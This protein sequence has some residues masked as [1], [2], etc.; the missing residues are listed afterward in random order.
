MAPEIITR[1]GYNF[2]ADFYTLGTL[3]YE[4]VVG[5]PPYLADRQR[6]LFDKIINQEPYYPPHISPNLKLFLSQLLEKNL[7]ER[8]GS[9]HGLS[10]IVNHPW[11]RDLDIV[12]I[13]QK[14]IK[15]P[16]IPDIYRINFAREFI[17]ARATFVDN[18]TSP[19]MNHNAP[20]HFPSAQP[21]TIGE[22][23]NPGM[24]RKFA[25]F[26]FYSN[27]DDPY[28]KF[29]DSIFVS[30]ENTPV[31]SPREERGDA[32]NKHTKNILSGEILKGLTF[33]V[34]LNFFDHSLF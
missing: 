34:F 29:Q 19:T 1:S 23:D 6:D 24:Y 4:M 15:A 25:N 27:I 18:S 31:S 20:S 3:V 11:C 13:A 16:I 8:L 9:K 22:M 26:S 32:K 17:D 2:S 33:E 12:K 21:E 28:E 10:E 5:R 7:H 14:K 30:N